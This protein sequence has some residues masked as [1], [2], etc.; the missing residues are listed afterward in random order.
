MDTGQLTFVRC[1]FLQIGLLHE[2]SAA[3][4]SGYDSYLARSGEIR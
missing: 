3:R 4:Y 2:D 1:L